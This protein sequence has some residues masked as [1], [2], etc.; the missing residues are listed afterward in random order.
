MNASTL[1]PGDIMSRVSYMTVVS[2]SGSSV[3]VENE[4]GFRWTIAKSVLE[5][6]AHTTSQFTEEVKVNRTELARMLEQ[7]ARDTAFSVC[8]T[9]LPDAEDQEAALAS[10][11]ISTP[12]KRKRVARELGIGKERIMHGHLLDTHELG[13]MP[14][15]DLEARGERLV[16]LRTLKWSSDICTACG[17]GRERAPCTAR[18]PRLTAA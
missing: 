18:P 2:V 5:A 12:A 14:T 10:A 4:D 1:K 8:F 9:K 3:E 15:F 16:D 13:R 6:E 17:S 11:D 7:D